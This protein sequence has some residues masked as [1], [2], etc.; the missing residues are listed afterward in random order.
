MSSRKAREIAGDK[1]ICLPIEDGVEYEDL[2]QNPK[3]GDSLWVTG[4]RKLSG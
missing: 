3:E 1:T 2:V 4:Q